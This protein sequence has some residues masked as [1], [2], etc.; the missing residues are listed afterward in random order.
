M[1]TATGPTTTTP[2]PI[3]MPCVAQHCWWLRP[4]R[5]PRLVQSWREV[6]VEG[7]AR[8]RGGRSARRQRLPARAQLV[9]SLPARPVEGCIPTRQR[10]GR[11]GRVSAPNIDGWRDILPQLEAQPAV[12]KV[13]QE[14]LLQLRRI[15]VVFRDRCFNCLSYSHRVATCR[16]P[17]H[18]LRCHGFRHIAREC[19]RLRSA[20]KGGDPPCCPV[21][22][23]NSSAS[24][25]ATRGDQMVS[26]GAVRGA[27]TGAGKIRR[28]RRQR[29]STPAGDISMGAPADFFDN[30]DSATIAY[31]SPMPDPLELELC[32]GEGPSAW[33]DPMLEEL[34]AS[35]ALT[36][37]PPAVE[38]SP[39]PTPVVSHGVDASLGTP[40]P[41]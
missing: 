11:H 22:G 6:E 33:D 41:Q 35:L 30:T 12:V 36:V 9:H 25:H 1:T 38:C 31:L 18:C 20:A 14:Q 32:A 29:R 37:G 7:A 3:S 28:R 4:H 21:R 13:Q 17:W 5:T 8:G 19:K 34:V 2:H 24:Q 39:P 16:L 15:P 40:I 26:G 23:I 27:A 10:F